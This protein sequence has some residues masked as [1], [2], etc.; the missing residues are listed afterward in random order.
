[1]G[2]TCTDRVHRILEKFEMVP[3]L[4]TPLGSKYTYEKPEK[5]YKMSYFKL[6]STVGNNEELFVK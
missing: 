6:K 3:K 2:A 5:E 4:P 1:M